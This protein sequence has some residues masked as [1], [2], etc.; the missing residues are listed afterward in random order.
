M[1]RIHVATLGLALGLGGLF[2]AAGTAWTAQKEKEKS[3][4]SDCC[5]CSK[6][7]KD[8]KA[9]MSGMACCMKHKK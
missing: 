3:N 8:A 1:K 5:C 7:D 6:A 4:C 2:Y 9:D